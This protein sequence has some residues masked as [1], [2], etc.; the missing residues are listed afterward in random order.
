M[1]QK[2]ASYSFI[3]CEIISARNCYVKVI[4]KFIRKLAAYLSRLDSESHSKYK[5]TFIDYTE[6]CEKLAISMLTYY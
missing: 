3:W 6:L 5:N 4:I 1:S 2:E